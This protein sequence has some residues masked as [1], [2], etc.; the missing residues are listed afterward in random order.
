M[1]PTAR[2]TSQASSGD[3]ERSRGVAQV[4][5]DQRA[6]V[7]RHLGERRHVG[8][9]G[10]AVGDV[11][12]EYDGGLR[13]EDGRQLIGGDAF[14]RVDIDPAQG[15][16]AL[17]RDALGDVAV[18]REVVAVDHDLGATRAQRHRGPEQ[19]VEEHR[20]RVADGGL[21]GCGAEHDPAEVVADHLGQLEPA[22]VPATD[23]PAAPLLLDEPLQPRPGHLERAAQGVAIE[24]G[25]RRLGSNEVIAERRQRVVAVQVLGALHGP[26]LQHKPYWNDTNRTSGRRRCT[27]AEPI[28]GRSSS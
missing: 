4:P 8:H 27:S 11:A 16:P 28:R 13:A 21:A 10:G 6:G 15:Q 26:C 3:R 1:Q 12:D 5:E 18:G 20:R 24:V 25:Q 14:T 9:P 17:L 2:S 23:Q 22:L 7:V 19:L